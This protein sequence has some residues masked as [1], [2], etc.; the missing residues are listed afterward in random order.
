V[1]CLMRQKKELRTKHDC[2]FNNKIGL[3][4][5]I[6]IILLGKPSRYDQ[7]VYNNMYLFICVHTEHYNGCQNRHD[8]VA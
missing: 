6:G 4:V 2:M 7:D 8:N 5:S 1:K 3:F